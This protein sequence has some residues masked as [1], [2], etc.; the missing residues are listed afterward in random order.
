MRIPLLAAAAAMTLFSA[1]PAPAQDAACDAAGAVTSGGSA[2]ADGTSATTAGAGG[3]CQTDAGIEAGVASGGSAAAVDGK[4]QS[5]TKV[6]DNPNNLKAVSKAQAQDGGT[7]SK[8][9]TKT[10]VRDG[11]TLESRTKTMAHVPGEKPVKERVET[12]AELSV[13]TE[14]ATADSNSC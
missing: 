11:E 10:S 7:F 2:A 4:V 12:Q 14:C 9:M 5:R 3:A 8:S 1:A 6:N 13:P